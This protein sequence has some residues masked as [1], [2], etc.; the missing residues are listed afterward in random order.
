MVG[1]DLLGGEEER[2]GI[3][4]ELVLV[5]V[6]ILCKSSDVARNQGLSS[7]QL[8]MAPEGSGREPG[9]LGRRDGMRQGTSDRTRG[10]C[11]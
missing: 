8:Q 4:V 2:K 6:V 7:G 9:E 10:R 5:D 3:E 11:G 1:L